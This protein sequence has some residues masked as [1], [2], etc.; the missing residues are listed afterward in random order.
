MEEMSNTTF[1]LTMKVL[2]S[3]CTDLQSTL[4]GPTLILIKRKLNNHRRHYYSSLLLLF[5]LL[6]S[7]STLVV[8]NVNTVKINIGKE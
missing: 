1:E 8:C 4:H 6:N 2:Y 7:D 3:F 5:F